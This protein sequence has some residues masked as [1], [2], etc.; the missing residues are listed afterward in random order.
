MSGKIKKEWKVIITFEP[1]R[2]EDKH[3]GQAYEKIVPPIKRQIQSKEVKYVQNS[4]SN[5]KSKEL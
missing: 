1:S 5:K 4:F 2:V 3:L